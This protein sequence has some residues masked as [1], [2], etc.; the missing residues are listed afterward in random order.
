MASDRGEVFLFYAPI[1]GTIDTSDATAS[2]LGE[3]AGD[4]AG[5]GVAFADV[6]GDTSTD[7]L[8]GAPSADGGAGSV[9]VF[10]PDD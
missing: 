3:R 9:Y 7:I 1:V 5:Q 4:F 10:T 8:V 6:D 2:F